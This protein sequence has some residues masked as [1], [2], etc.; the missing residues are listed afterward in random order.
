[1]LSI[2]AV[3]SGVLLVVYAMLTWVI[4]GRVLGLGAADYGLVPIRRGVRGFGWGTLLGTGMAVLV[5]AVAVPLGQAAWREDGGT[6]GAWVGTVANTGAILLP[7]AL[8]EEVMF[9]G[10]PM[11]ALARG[12][13][14]TPAMLIL[15]G[16][17]GLGHLLNP[18][19]TA[20]AVANIVLAGVWLG[21]VFFTPGGLWA[22]TGAH[23][24]WNLAI[25]ALAAPV[26]GLPFP[27][28]WL[29]YASGG[30]QW[31]TGGT[32]GPEGGLLAT[33]GLAA[34]TVAAVRRTRPEQR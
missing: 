7:A 30:P 17:F 9:R 18:G 12:F 2:A 33:L 24:G 16:L 31:L 23:V 22:A 26:S 6:V 8:V 21:A 20:L 15:A 14:R 13:G 11:V 32:F 25:A 10:M 34:G 1:V 28:P 4:G 3:Q 19:I 27:M 29:D 5:M